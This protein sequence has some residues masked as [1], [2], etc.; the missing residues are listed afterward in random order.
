MK[1]ATIVTDIKRV[2]TRSKIIV[3][4]R[5]GVWLGIAKSEVYNARITR[6]AGT[7][8]RAHRKSLV[9]SRWSFHGALN[10]SRISWLPL[11]NVED[12]PAIGV[13]S[14]LHISNLD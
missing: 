13:A 5:I 1:Y 10:S 7:P 11:E 3:W 8:S 4:R 2:R 14:G 6:G 9:W 12:C